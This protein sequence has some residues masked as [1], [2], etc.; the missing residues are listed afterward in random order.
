M[1]LKYLCRAYFEVKGKY[2]GFPYEE[3]LLKVAT[4]GQTPEDVFY[5]L[6]GY[7]HDNIL[8]A[9]ERFK[10]RKL[11]S[12]GNIK[13]LSSIFKLKD[14]NDLVEVLEKMDCS[15]ARGMVRPVK[16]QD[17][18][19]ASLVRL[20][21]DYLLNNEEKIIWQG[22]EPKFF[23]ELLKPLRYL[24]SKKELDATLDSDR[25]RAAL[26]LVLPDFVYKKGCTPVISQE[27]FFIPFNLNKNQIQDLITSAVTHAVIRSLD[28]P[29]QVYFHL[30]HNA[31]NYQTF[32]DDAYLRIVDWSHSLGMT[33][34][35]MFDKCGMKHVDRFDYYERFKVIPYLS[36]EDKITVY[37]SESHT[38]KQFIVLSTNQIMQLVNSNTLRT[39]HWDNGVPHIYLNGKQDLRLVFGVESTVDFSVGGV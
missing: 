18:G 37:S 29:A 14:K 20:L 39:L 6:I 28:V 3:D 9:T 8:T 1:Y 12:E 33:V 21:S 19:F 15:S 5:N 4:S 35:E 17:E 38:D 7:K 11:S 30:V 32:K 34:Q 22:N 31:L 16:I 13:K 36:G 26:K 10:Y 23:Y 27:V 24:K 25:F 2:E